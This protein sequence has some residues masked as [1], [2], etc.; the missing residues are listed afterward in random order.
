M[1]IKTRHV[2]SVVVGVCAKLSLNVP[3]VHRV[4]YG[5]ALRELLGPWSDIWRDESRTQCTAT[6][7]LNTGSPCND[8]ETRS[9]TQPE[10]PIPDIGIEPMRNLAVATS[11]AVI[12]KFR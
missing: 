3:K 6:H 5:H 4:L 7:L 12:P 1:R 9:L 10:W 11:K 8:K 2:H